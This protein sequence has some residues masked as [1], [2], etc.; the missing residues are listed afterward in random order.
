SD[1]IPRIVSGGW[2]RGQMLIFASVVAGVRACRWPGWRRV[3]GFRVSRVRGFA[4][5]VVRAGRGGPAG[6]RGP[7]RGGRGR[8]E[9]FDHGFAAADAVTGQDGLAAGSG[10]ELGPPSASTS[11]TT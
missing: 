2:S 1:P 5:R 7:R 8:A 10:G 4:G 11:S 9:G 3:R 6:E